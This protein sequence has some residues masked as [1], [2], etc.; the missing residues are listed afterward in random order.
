LQALF[1]LPQQPPSA[2]SSPD[3]SLSTLETPAGAHPGPRPFSLPLKLLSWGVPSLRY[4]VSHTAGAGPA[5]P[6]RSGGSSATTSHH[7][8]PHTRQHRRT[9]AGTSRPAQP[10]HRRRAQALRGHQAWSGRDLAA[11]A[12]QG[13][14]ARH[15]CS[16]IIMTLDPS[17]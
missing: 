17:W 12:A 15:S 5:V 1:P 14:C 3:A 7:P 9:P 2:V 4:D 11:E 10:A 6:S 8:D 16:R 13:G